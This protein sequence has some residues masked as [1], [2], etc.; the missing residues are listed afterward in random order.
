[1]FIRKLASGVVVVPGAEEVGG[2]H[3]AVVAAVLLN[4]SKP[5]PHSLIDDN[6]LR[7]DDGWRE[8]LR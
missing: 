5:D 1:M 3:A 4:T 6:R 2:H 7:A 8:S